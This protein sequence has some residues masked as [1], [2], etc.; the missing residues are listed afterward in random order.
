MPLKPLA[1]ELVP[2]VHHIEL[3]KAGWG[4]RLAEQLMSAAAHSSPQAASAAELQ[5]RIEQQ[6]GLHMTAADLRR[7]I[8]ALCSKKTLLEV[9]PDRFKISEA[10]R[11]AL[12]RQ[13]AETAE[14]EKTAKSAFEEILTKHGIGGGDAWGAFNQH[15]LS[16]LVSDI[17]ARIYHVLSGQPPTAEQQRHVE[18]Y[19]SRF[20]NDQQGS[21]ALAV[22]E[23]IR[24]G[25]SG[26]RRF[27]LQH[28]HAHLLLRAASLPESTLASLQQ[29]LKSTTLLTLVVDTNVLFS[30]LDLHENPGNDPSRDLLS[31]AGRLK[32][33][34]GI[35]LVVLPLTL[36]E[37]KRT[38]LYYKQKLA[39]LDVTSVLGRAAL[40]SDDWVSGITQRFLQ[41]ASRG[42]PRLSADAY[43]EPYLEDLTAVAKSKG[44]EL[45]NE[46]TTKLGT[47]QDVVDDILAQQERENARSERPK[48]YEAI[49]H[50]VVLWHTVRDRRGT[51]SQG[52]LSATPWLVTLDFQLLGFDSFK[53]RDRPSYVPICVHPTVLVQLLQLWLPRD[54]SIDDALLNSLRPM[55][56]HEFDPQAEE[57]TVRILA[58]LSRYE[59]VDDLGEETIAEI[60]MNQ[61]LRQRMRGEKDIERQTRLVKD[62]IIAQAEEVKR[63]LK[64]ATDDT[65]Q[66]AASLRDEQLR[67]EALAED[68]RAARS[69]AEG[70]ER[71]AGAAA[72][73]TEELRERLGTVELELKQRNERSRQAEIHGRRVR[74]ASTAAATLIAGLLGLGILA[75]WLAARMALDPPRA[76]LG[77]IVAW[78]A[79]WIQIVYW[80][81]QRVA[82][83]KTWAPYSLFCRCRGAIWTVAGALLLG[84][85]SNRVYDVLK[86]IFGW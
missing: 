12:E 80:R 64:R 39:R 70:H 50:D 32:G 38:L 75:Y 55:L 41:A 19:V 79:L 74:F 63:A 67:R 26:A 24:S 77:T 47:R 34:L 27:I 83:I 33:R 35:R 56:P 20:P 84:V 54:A 10:H 22:D 45:Y 42:K 60:L 31:L 16:P 1:A 4:L 30:L 11:E 9:E 2:L 61:A 40:R 36:D 51:D 65:E 3:A 44:I 72:T 68:L 6:Y 48:P 58:S 86:R 15:C 76:V 43:F 21:V 23:F 5:Q 13:F 18:S 78:S 57:V 14:L 71:Q 29:R 69:Q 17:G 7:A 28:L 82:A 37:A 59:N 25:P 81:G 52:P 53:N 66:L 62:A 73:L 49:R 8:G 46:N 85:T